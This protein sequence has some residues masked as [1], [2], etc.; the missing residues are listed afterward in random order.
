MV[1]TETYKKVGLD[2]GSFPVGHNR[3]RV[4]LLHGDNNRFINYSRAIFGS[5]I[6]SEATDVLSVVVKTEN[7]LTNGRGKNVKRA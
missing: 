3:Y 4:M 5:A 1:V 6:I 7:K 2:V